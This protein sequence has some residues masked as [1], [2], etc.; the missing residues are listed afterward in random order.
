MVDSLIMSEIPEHIFQE[1]FPESLE[2]AIENAMENAYYPPEYGANPEKTRFVK[3][4]FL[5]QHRIDMFLENICGF[6]VCAMDYRWHNALK[7]QIIKN[8]VNNIESK[9]DINYE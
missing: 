6:N 7:C 2:K 9:K 1:K 4:D 8:I 3:N 5:V